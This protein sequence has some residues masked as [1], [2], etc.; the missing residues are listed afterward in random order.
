MSDARQDRLIADVL[1]FP[2]LGA[3]YG[4][5]EQF[6]NL[7]EHDSRAKAEAA[8]KRWRD[9]MPKELRPFFKPVLTMMA[10]WGGLIFNYYEAR[11][12][13]GTVERMNRSID[14]INAAG[15]GYDFDTLRA[16]ALLRYGN[17]IPLGDLVNFELTSVAPEDRAAL[18]DTPVVRGFDPSTLG[19]ALRAGR[20]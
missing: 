20:F 12:T 8:Y 19:R 11:D 10:N 5:K 4:Y 14:A 1:A 16:K 15:S 13:S 18:V 9:E 3:A 17:I 7:Y 6:F 2:F